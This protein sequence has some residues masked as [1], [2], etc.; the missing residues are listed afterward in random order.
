MKCWCIYILAQ[1]TNF[2]WVAEVWAL[3]G[4]FSLS[5]FCLWQ[6]CGWVTFFPLPG[7]YVQMRGRDRW[8]LSQSVWASAQGT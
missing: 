2:R 8:H 4:V 6:I 1:G 5:E 3:W 7:A